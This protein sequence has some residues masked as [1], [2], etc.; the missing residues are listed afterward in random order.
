MASSMA[1][2]D[3]ASWPND[4]QSTTGPIPPPDVIIQS[5]VPASPPTQKVITGVP[6]YIWYNGCGP[7]AVGMVVGFWDRTF[8][9]LV[10]GSSAGQTTAVNNMM[11]SSGNYNDY[12]VPIEDNGNLL[13]DRST[14]EPDQCHPDDCVA[15]FMHTSQSRYGNQYGWS[16]YSDVAPSFT[17]YC[18]YRLPGYKAT[19]TDHT[20]WGDLTFASYRKEIDANRPVVFL[21][22]SNGDGG[23]DHFITGIGYNSMGQYGYYNTWD[24]NVHWSNFAGMT[25]GSPWGIYGATYFNLQVPEPASIY[26]LICGLA[27]AGGLLRRRK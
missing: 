1:F 2:A 26:V 10:P 12:C 16:W 15:D 19:A 4:A 13:Q 6:A 17:D 8:T 5:E 21:V 11:S 9:N 23:T 24:T 25:S 22:D 14:L 7:T 3:P 27:T 20:F 18:N